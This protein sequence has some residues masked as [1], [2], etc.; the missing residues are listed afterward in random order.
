M[1]I[2]AKILM[3]YTM[4][5]AV[6]LLGDKGNTSKVGRE[7]KREE[8]LRLEKKKIEDKRKL[9]EERAK[10]QEVIKARAVISGPVQIR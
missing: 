8:A 3:I 6:N 5:C 1:Q 10:Q 9:D 7:K 4:F 2:Q